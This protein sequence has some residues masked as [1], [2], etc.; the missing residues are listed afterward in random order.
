M[1]IPKHYERLNESIE[2]IDECISKDIIKRQRTIGFSCSVASSDML[3]IFLHKKELIDSGFMLKHEWFK[4]KNKINEKLYFNFENKDEILNL[5]MKIE[6][7]RNS[8]CYG[9]PK[10][11]NE[12][13]DV[14][15]NF[16]KLKNIFKQLGVIINE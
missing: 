6:E 5:M 16:N 14:I 12:V 1:N 8:L 11:E 13:K 10:E 4:S 9:A 2:V 7:K 3:E 15:M